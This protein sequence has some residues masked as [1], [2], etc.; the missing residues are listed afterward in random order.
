M[1][2]PVLYPSISQSVRTKFYERLERNNLNDLPRFAGFDQATLRDLR[3][4]EAA[5]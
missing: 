1:E 5:A 4:T 3:T 2:T